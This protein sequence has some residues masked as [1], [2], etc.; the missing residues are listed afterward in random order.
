MLIESYQT[1]YPT[2]RLNNS[3]SINHA[4][5]K[6]TKMIKVFLLTPKPP[7]TRCTVTGS[8]CVDDNK[9]DRVSCFLMSIPTVTQWKY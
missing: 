7:D 1:S 3:P 2:I 9:P 5:L 6:S 4:K 8:L